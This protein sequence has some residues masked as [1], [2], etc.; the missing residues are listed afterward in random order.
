MRVPI[1]ALTAA[2][3]ALPGC[4]EA[5]ETES[6][7][8]PRT[9]VPAADAPA[10]DDPGASPGAAVAASSEEDPEPVADRTGGADAANAP[11]PERAERR[12]TLG[13]NPDFED[14]VAAREGDWVVI[15]GTVDGRHVDPPGPGSM[16][17]SVEEA[18]EPTLAEVQRRVW[19]A[20]LTPWVVASDHLPA[21][22]PGQTLLI[23]GP[24]TSAEADQ[25][26]EEVWEIAPEA[27]VEPG[28]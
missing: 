6:D 12:P 9:A 1:L 7:S 4:G 26:L 14:V 20:G 10:P 2:L 11:T 27:R 28:W 25:R 21:R 22:D 15:L 24:F 3:F 8:A 18:S 13:G 17:A 19:N 5:G 16:A 23:L